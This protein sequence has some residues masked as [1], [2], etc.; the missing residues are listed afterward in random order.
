MTTTPSPEALAEQ[1]ERIGTDNRYSNEWF[2]NFV[3]SRLADLLGFLRPTPGGEVVQGDRDGVDRESAAWDWLHGEA[4]DATDHVYSADEMVDAFLAGCDHRLA[5]SGAGEPIAYRYDHP[6]ESY[7]EPFGEQPLTEHDKE[8]GWTETPLYALATPPHL[9]PAEPV[10]DE[11]LVERVARDMRE[12]YGLYEG[13]V[14][15]P[16]DRARPE[17]K[18]AWFCCARAAIQAIP[19]PATD[20]GQSAD[21]LVE[22]AKSTVRWLEAIDRCDMGEIVADGGITA[23]M[24]VQQEARTQASRL[25]ASLLK[26]PSAGEEA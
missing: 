7:L 17:L 6:F 10:G 25:R 23:G 20:A 16:W 19:A 26:S 21:G 11:A 14:I 13:D 18:E 2:G 15:V 1:L 22:A 4:A 9:P 5:S 8:A 24:V 3:R 12:A